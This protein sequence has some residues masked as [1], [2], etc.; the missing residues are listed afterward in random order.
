MTLRTSPLPRR[1][2]TL[3]ELLVVIAIIAILIGLLLPAVQK[4]REAAN[5][6][7]CSNNLKQWALAMHNYNDTFGTLPIGASN[8]TAPYVR[9]TWVRF[10]WPFIEQQNLTN[11]DVPTSPFY[12]PPCTIGNTE[13]GLCGQKIPLYYCPSD[14]AGAD[15]DSSAAYYQRRRGNYVVNWGN[16]MYDTPPPGTGKAPF[17]HNNGNRATPGTVAIA[18][19]TDGL[20]NTLMMSETLRAWSHDDN[21]WRG[22]IQNDD[23]V[24]KFMTITTPN[25]TAPDVVNW[26]IPNNDPLMPV[27]TAGS[28][29]SAARSRHTGGVNVALCDGSIRFVRQTIALSTWQALGTMDGGEVVA[30]Y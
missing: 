6:L 30:N 27:T 12:N 10:L 25:S 16:T 5:R 3:I 20:S 11:K 19:I 29:Y 28:E 17:Y 14:G 23:G 13:N 7:K 24:F 1:G 18:T 9:Q 26:A 4:I 8:D 2:F 15:L 21:D 22:D